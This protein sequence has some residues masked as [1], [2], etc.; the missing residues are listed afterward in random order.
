MMPLTSTLRRRTILCEVGQIAA[1]CSVT[2][3]RELARQ[4]GAISKAVVARSAR[5]SNDSGGP[6]EPSADQHH[7]LVGRAELIEIA[8]YGGRGTQGTVVYQRGDLLTWRLYSG[9]RRHDDVRDP[10]RDLGI[11]WLRVEGN[12]GA[13]PGFPDISALQV[14]NCGIF[15]WVAR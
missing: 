1:N 14:K 6:G 10:Q 5:T 12:V 9:R 4:E 8:A 13:V 11:I 7:Y 15:W 2:T 3:E